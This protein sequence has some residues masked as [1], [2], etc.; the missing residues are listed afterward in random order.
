MKPT[1]VIML[2]EPRPG[3]VKTRLG[4]GIGMVGAAWWFRH[5]VSSL[6]RELADPHWQILLAVSPDVDGAKSRVWPARF[7]RIQQ[8]RGDLGDRMGRLFRG[9]PA[10]PVV[11]IGADIP[12]IKKSN[13]RA[14]FRALGRNQAVIGPAPDGGYWLIGLK[15]VARPPATLFEGV[16]WSSEHA[17]ADTLKSLGT[18]SVAMI[19]TKQDVDSVDDLRALRSNSMRDVP[20]SPC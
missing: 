5:Q 13:I 7:Q 19:E 10:G 1:L 15:R 6:L 2:K 3:R 14:A 16:R 8:G 12:N 18:Y 20:N 11:I 4:R 17:L 9:L